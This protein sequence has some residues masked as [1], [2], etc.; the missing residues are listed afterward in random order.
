MRC[1]ETRKFLG[2]YL[3]SELDAKT[4]LEI[5]QHLD[6]CLDCARVFAAEEKLDA[7]IFR[8][9][10][11]GQRTA[12]LW[13]SIESRIKPRRFAWVTV[14]IP[15][16]A[17][18]VAVVGFVWWK[19]HRL[20][21][22]VAAAHCHR[23]YVEHL[24][25]PETIGALPAGLDRAAFSVKP[26]SE[27]FQSQG[28]RVCHLQGVPVAAIL[29]R[30]DKVPVSMIVFRKSELDHFPETKRRLES[31]EPVVCAR[32]G[33]YHFAIRLL[34]DHVL[35]AIGET[36]MARLEELVKSAS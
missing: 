34:G 9:L 24:I 10:R 5:Q 1:H 7:R 11:Q 25:A 26:A 22:A 18:M 23:E 32:V 31:G 2:P 36:P 8:G 13:D 29:G 17:C 21:V 33:R 19:T 16:A 14:A 15:A 4:S 3:D 28:A 27:T 20:E 12:E 6:S 35:C 30:C